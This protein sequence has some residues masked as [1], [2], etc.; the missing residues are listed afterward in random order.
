MGMKSSWRTG[1]CTLTSLFL[2]HPSHDYE[3]YGSPLVHSVASVYN[4]KTFSSSSSTWRT[5]FFAYKIQSIR[6]VFIESSKY[7]VLEG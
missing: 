7:F 2:E 6:S 3:S 1:V 5:L 4:A